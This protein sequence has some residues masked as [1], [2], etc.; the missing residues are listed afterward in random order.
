MVPSTIPFP[1]VASAL[2]LPG[3][4]GALEVCVDLPEP[5]DARS[6]LAIM[7]HPHPL[8]GG[9]MHN[10][11]VTMVARSLRELGLA[12]IRFNFRGVGASEGVYDNGRGET[13]DL[14]AVA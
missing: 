2:S 5:A 14:L 11:V 4:A 13:L 6:G 12:T 8:E 9:T 10:K 3:P 1:E 7:C